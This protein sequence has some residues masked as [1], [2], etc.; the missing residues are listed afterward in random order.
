MFVQV[1]TILMIDRDALPSD[2]F[3]RFPRANRT[4]PLESE[5]KFSVQL[6]ESSSP[7]V[8]AGPT[9]SHNEQGLCL[10]CL[11]W[12]VGK[13]GVICRRIGDTGDRPQT[14]RY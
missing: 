12:Y 1:F 7:A 10:R 11:F 13:R 3:E 8:G 9:S 6:Q 14:G 4:A 2:H 5:L